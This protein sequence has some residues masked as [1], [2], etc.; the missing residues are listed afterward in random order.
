M[1]SSFAPPLHTS[2]IISSASESESFSSIKGY[3][4][5]TKGVLQYNWRESSDGYDAPLA[6]L[7]ID[8][9][10]EAGGGLRFPDNETGA[11]KIDA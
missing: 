11:K 6:K 7:F 5:G 3:K 10:A 4:K 9:M 1:S 8:G 2:R